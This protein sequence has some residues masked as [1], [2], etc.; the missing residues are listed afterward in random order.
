[1]A[2]G[3]GT[4][5]QDWPPTASGAMAEPGG[6]D[7][8]DVLLVEDDDGDA[9][10]VEDVLGGT[11]PGTR[12][13][14][15]SSLAEALDSLGPGIDCVVLDLRLPD[16]E[17]LET[18][19]RLRDTAPELPLIV[20]TGL[21]DEAAGVAAVA[22]GAQDYLV[23]GDDDH[24]RLARAIRYSIGR[25]QAADAQQQLRLAE[26]QAREVARLERG[27][28]PKPVIEEPSIWVASKYCAGRNRAL[29]GGDFFDVA[30]APDGRLRAMVGDV[31]GHGPDEAALG[32]CLRAAWRALAVSGVAGAVAVR[33]LERVLEHEREIPHLFATL[34]TV[35]VR[36][37]DGAAEILLAGHPPPVLIDGAAVTIMPE[38]PRGPAIGIVE[39]TWP[40]MPM[41]LPAGWTMLLYT[42][43]ITDARIEGE[44]GER[45]GTDGLERLVSEHVDTHPDWRTRP[46]ELLEQLI[47]RAEALNGGALTD[48]VALLLVGSLA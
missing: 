5:P 36:P 20:L 39:G 28:A 34:C 10:L 17:G 23:K 8:I 9:L 38:T 26:V 25:R 46:D 6:R 18:V 40:L 43:G 47:A 3:T 44:D 41:T 14:R 22:A 21:D 35:E 4:D 30:E 19:I 29:L 2:S 16:A 42:D 45:L 48:D 32:V 11:L 15:S 27:L 7:Q 1:M 24:G 37:S 13:H 33:A 31:C 12:V